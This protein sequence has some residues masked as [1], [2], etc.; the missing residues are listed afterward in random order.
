MIYLLS[1]D[2]K[3]MW[4]RPGDFFYKTPHRFFLPSQRRRP[5]AS[6]FH[7]KV[8]ILAWGRQRRGGGGVNTPTPSLNPARFFLTSLISRVTKFIQ[9]VVKRTTYDH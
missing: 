9:L 2:D 6:K 5:H 1:S 3:K 8:Y 7:L 4:G